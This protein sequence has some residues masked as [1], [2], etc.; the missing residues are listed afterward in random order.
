MS[1]QPLALR[2]SDADLAALAQ[3]PDGNPTRSDRLA[4]PRSAAAA[5]RVVPAAVNSSSAR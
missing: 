4:R 2:R 1:L 5:G 3:A